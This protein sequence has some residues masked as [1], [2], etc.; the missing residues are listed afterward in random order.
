MVLPGALDRGMEFVEFAG[1]TVQRH[2]GVGDIVAHDEEAHR[3]V[4]RRRADGIALL[5]TV[6]YLEVVHDVVGHGIAAVTHVALLVGIR[7]LIE[8]RFLHQVID[9]HGLG[10]RHEALHFQA[11]GIVLEFAAMAAALVTEHL[12]GVPGALHHKITVI[13]KPTD[14]AASI[15]RHLLGILAAA[16]GLGDCCLVQAL[17]GHHGQPCM[18]VSFH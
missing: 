2:V 14:E 5:F 8:F 18:S 3:H 16:L 11:D 1:I 13:L 15:F 6:L 4:G 12:I 10:Q 9:L 7:L 17:H